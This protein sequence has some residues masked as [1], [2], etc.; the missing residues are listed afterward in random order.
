MQK[1]YEYESCFDY[2]DHTVRC[3]Q[4]LRLNISL[5]ILCFVLLMYLFNAIIPIMKKKIKLF[6]ITMV[7]SLTVHFSY[8]FLSF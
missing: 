6:F 1:R 2:I 8:I 7:L 3:F 4:H 5:H